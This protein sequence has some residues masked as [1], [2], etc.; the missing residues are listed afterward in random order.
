[1]AKP[2]KLVKAGEVFPGLV[3]E[4]IT[5]VQIAKYA[6]AS[7]DFNP[8]HLDDAPGLALGTG[9]IIAHGMLVMGFAGQA[10]TNWVPKRGLR[11]FRVRFVGMTR[12]GD[13]ITVRGKIKEI[14]Q[15]AG[16]YRLTCEVTAS[17]QEGN[18]KLVGSFVATLPPTAEIAL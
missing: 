12:P 17:D 6:G 14:Q 1:M 16:E 4:P 11:E 2:V 10:I 3:K 15:E 7:G 9:G 13:V 8:L 18:L 5:K